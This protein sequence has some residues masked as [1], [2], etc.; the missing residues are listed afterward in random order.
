LPGFDENSYAQSSNA[1]RRSKKD[2]IDE[3]KILRRS[4]EQLF[5]SFDNDQLKGTGIA[6]NNSVSVEAIGFITAGHAKHHINILKERYL[7]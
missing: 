3:Y 1:D 2:L 4:V 5:A 6:N 7:Q